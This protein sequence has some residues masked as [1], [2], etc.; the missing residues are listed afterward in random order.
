[1]GEDRFR[2]V[3]TLGLPNYEFPQD[4]FTQQ[5]VENIYSY[6]P[7][8]FGD[9]TI[10]A[11][12]GGTVPVQWLGRPG[13]Y[14]QTISDLSSGAWTDLYDTDGTTWTTGSM[15]PSGFISLTNYP[16]STGATFFRLVKPS[17]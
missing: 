14:L 16:V 3:R 11:P 13:V 10:G 17:L 12:S 6:P 15:G 5:Y 7:R 8:D 1:M 9:L 2:D 4:T